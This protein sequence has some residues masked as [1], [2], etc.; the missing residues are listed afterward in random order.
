MTPLYQ[1]IARCLAAQENCRKTGNTEWLSRH[2]DTI[3]HLVNIYMP[4]GSGIDSGTKLDFDRSRPNRLVFTAPYH[5][6]N[7]GG[8][9]DGW[10]DH[11]IIVT[12]NLS[13]GGFDLRITGRDRNQIKDYLGD[14][15]AEALRQDITDD[16]YRAA[17][18]VTD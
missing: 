5:H 10:T 4:S 17:C 1:H 7:D 11:D 2:G 18:G 15:F 12:P 9:Y 13:F 6:M 8:M 16:E 14:T 3:N